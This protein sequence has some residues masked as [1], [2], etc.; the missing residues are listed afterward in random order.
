MATLKNGKL[1]GN[2]NISTW[3]FLR[4][5]TSTAVVYTT[6]V[7]VMHSTLIISLAD[8]KHHARLTWA[9]I[10]LNAYFGASLPSCILISRAYDMVQNSRRLLILR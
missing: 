3:H 9:V 6:A 10:P 8:Q 1:E 7:I 5:Y 4:V 2:L